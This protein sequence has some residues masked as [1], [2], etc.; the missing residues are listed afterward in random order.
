MAMEKAI[1]ATRRCLEG[2]PVRHDQE[3]MIADQAQDFIHYVVELLRDPAKRKNLG[4]KARAKVE[5]EFGAER[6]T[7]GYEKLYQELFQ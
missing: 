1:V 3:V 6:L 5:V 2:F 7:A 4:Q